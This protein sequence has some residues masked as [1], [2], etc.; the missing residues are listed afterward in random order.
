MR[1]ESRSKGM[2]PKAWLGVVGAVV[3]GIV[4]AN[5]VRT[6]A[7]EGGISAAGSLFEKAPE[8]LQHLDTLTY[9]P[10]APDSEVSWGGR[11]VGRVAGQRR[12]PRALEGGFAEGFIV[13][14]GSWLDPEPSTW[15]AGLLARLVEAEGDP[16]RVRIELFVGAA[17]SEERPIGQLW[18]NGE[19]VVPLY[20][21]T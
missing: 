13:Y 18:M 12:L 8:L 10:V 3:A 4:L 21:G 11:V 2:S 9:S 1:G 14:Q 17:A 20:R 5:V 19:Q 16:P 6:A 7:T 15:P